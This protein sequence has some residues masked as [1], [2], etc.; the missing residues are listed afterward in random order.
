WFFLAFRAGSIMR[1]YYNIHCQNA[2]SLENL[3][4]TVSDDAEFKAPALNV[5]DLAINAK[6][7]GEVKIS[8]GIMAG[9]VVATVTDHAEFKSASISANE[10]AL[11]ATGDSEIKL[12]DC[13]L[14]RLTGVSG[15][16]A[17]IK[18]SGKCS[19]VSYT[20]KGNSQ[21]VADELV[22][23]GGVATANDMSTI[24]TNVA[25]LQTNVDS[26]MATIKNFR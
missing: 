6:D 2:L 23:N 22:A 21:I 10:V 15:D 17:E 13:G 24:R 7:N 5:N 8:Q 1:E 14:E 19:I 12:K 25:S 18:L 11:T 16:N 4:I 26:E 20:A 3:A 9:N